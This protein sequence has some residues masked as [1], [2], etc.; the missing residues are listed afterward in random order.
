MA[1]FNIALVAIILSSIGFNLVQACENKCREDP[2]SFLVKKYEA[3]LQH[4]A[5]T[6]IPAQTK[7]QG[8]KLIRRVLHKLKGKHNVIDSTIF[9]KFR[10]PCV[11]P[12]VGLRSPEEF[13]GSAKAIACFAPWGHHKSVFDSVHSAVVDVLR[14]T[15]KH[16]TPQ[17]RAAMV[18]GVDSFC[19]NN[20]QDWV[21]PFQ[22]IMLV[23]EQ[24]E[25]PHEY[26]VTPNCLALG[27]GGI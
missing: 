5:N 3:V 15:Y 6:L 24:R 16:Q 13:C 10:G 1:R 8:R 9:D 25:H 23:W 4:Q 27:H 26:K 12:G 20:C 19:P 17:V 14:A 2:V 7:S 22:N 11:E 18:D 21:A